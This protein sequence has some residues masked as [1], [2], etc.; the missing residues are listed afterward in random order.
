MSN[1]YQGATD[2]EASVLNHMQENRWYPASWLVNK[3]WPTAKGPRPIGF[4]RGRNQRMGAILKK[5][6]DKNLVFV[7]RTEYNQKLWRKCEQVVQAKCKQCGYEELVWK[8]HEKTHICMDCT[9]CMDD[10]K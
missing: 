2:F 10:S 1:M 4:D 9:A 7:K 8:S 3:V 6:L 5:M